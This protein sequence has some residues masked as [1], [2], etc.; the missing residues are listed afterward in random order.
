M[1]AWDD[2]RM[3]HGVSRETLDALEAYRDLLVRWQSKINLV[4]PSTLDQFWDRHVLDCA[5]LWTLCPGTRTWLD[6]GSGAGLPGLIIASLGQT[7]GC[8]VIL[9]ESSAKRCAFLREAARVLGVRASVDILNTKIETL[10]LSALHPRPT[11]MTARAFTAL[12]RLLELACPLAET[13]AI[14]LFPKGADYEREIEDSLSSWAFSVTTHRSVTD[15]AA[16]IL[17]IDDLRHVP[18][19]T[20]SA[21][22]NNG[23][24]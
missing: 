10:D 8:R 13:G 16:A 4:G 11:V 12:K 15:P 19:Q 14:L 17:Q 1:S 7:T 22:R 2:F 24:R 6:V 23:I 5:Q 18:D 21:A 3:Q 9:V 20:G